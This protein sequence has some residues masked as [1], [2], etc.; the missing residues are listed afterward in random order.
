VP[1]AHCR[2]SLKIVQDGRAWL[3]MILV[4]T[5]LLQACQRNGVTSKASDYRLNV[6]TEALKRSPE[7]LFII[8]DGFSGPL[9]IV[10][11]SSDGRQLT[12]VTNRL[13]IEFPENGIVAVK[14]FAPLEKP[15][16]LIAQYSS[17]PLLKVDPEEIPSSLETNLWPIGSF[18][19]TK[20]PLETFIYLVCPAS[21]LDALGR[22]LR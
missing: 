5:L 11:D 9:R 16:V 1:F 15:H 12:L 14:D 2:R 3:M 19:G 20:Y 4:L 18:H 13:V 8:P 6:D 21:E 22:G 10:K 7:V 17:G